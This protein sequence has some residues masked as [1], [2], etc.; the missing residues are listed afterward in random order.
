MLPVL[1]SSTKKYAVVIGINYYNTSSE[2]SGCIND[3]NNLKT[4]LTQKAQ[5]LP[6]NILTLVD[7]GTTIRPTKQNIINSFNTLISKA[8][9]GFTEL[10][11]SYSGHGAFVTDTNNDESDRQDEVICPVD[12]TT[13]GMITDDFIYTNLVAKLP[14][15]VTLFALMDSCYSGSVL[16]LPFIYN[17]SF[18][19]NNNHTNHVASVISISGCRDDQ[20]SS[21]A[22]LNNTYQGAMTWSFLKAINDAN[23]NIKTVDLVKNMRTL[24][25]GKFTQVPLLA[26]SSS[27]EYERQFMQSS[28]VPITT[29]PIVPIVPILPMTK[30]IKFKLTADYWF[31][32]SSWNVWS[33]ATNNYIFPKNNVFTAKYQTVTLVKDLL[34]GDYKLC[35][36]DSYGDG[37]VTALVTDGLKTL[38]SAKVYTGKLA[39]Y[40]FTI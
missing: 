2:L 28:L 8:N 40:K 3:A 30:S 33:F 17:L 22:Y 14:A 1:S 27:N 32:E 19:T 15:T 24:L 4:F 9:E 34:L 7:N 26:V 11:I 5:Y 20:L 21:D 16:D 18:T 12:Y 37:G 31:K 13:A 6:E 29:I 39:E 23:Y 25:V 10:W 38:V 36:N 35:I